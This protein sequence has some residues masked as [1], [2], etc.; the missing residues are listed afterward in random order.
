MCGTLLTVLIFLFIH[1]INKYLLTSLIYYF[2]VSDF[3]GAAERYVLPVA[4]N[5]LLGSDAPRTANNNSW[6]LTRAM[7]TLL[8]EVQLD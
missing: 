2:S 8:V 4:A 6:K 1:W 3:S 7:L 5:T